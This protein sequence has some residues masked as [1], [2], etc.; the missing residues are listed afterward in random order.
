MLAALQEL[1]IAFDPLL[2]YADG[3][4]VFP[5]LLELGFGFLE[6]VAFWKGPKQH[7]PLFAA[8]EGAL[9]EVGA[10]YDDG[11]YA[12]FI[13]EVSFGMQIALVNACLDVG[14]LQQLAQ[15]I[16]V[17]EVEIGRCEDTPGYAALLQFVENLC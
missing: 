2:C 7:V 15:G 4:V 16:G 13:K 10:S 8:G 11:R 12:F 1:L 5:E 6:D 14:V 3:V 17:V 9:R